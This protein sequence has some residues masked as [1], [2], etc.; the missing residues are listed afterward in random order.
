MGH[1]TK[2]ALPEPSQR[3]RV[4][5]RLLSLRAGGVG[6]GEGGRETPASL[7][8]PGGLA[9]WNGTFQSI[10]RARSHCPAGTWEVRQS[11]ATLSL[12]P[13]APILGNLLASAVPTA[14]PLSCVGSLV[15]TVSLHL[16][17]QAS[18][19]TASWQLPT[20]ALTSLLSYRS[21]LESPDGSETPDRG[22]H[23]PA[24]HSGAPNPPA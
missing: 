8:V 2:K 23:T 1:R 21:C 4:P 24:E 18:S 20:P 16:T 11:G 14:L 17:S 12:P 13:R 22:Q 6:F 3:V 10:H 5:L 19:S 15:F 7:G 9:G